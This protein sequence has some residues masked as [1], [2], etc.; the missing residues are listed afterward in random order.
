MPANLL[1]LLGRPASAEASLRA[2]AAVSAYF[3]PAT[4]CALF[5]RHRPEEAVL[6]GEEVLTTSRRA[7]LQEAE[8][9]RLAAL[10]QLFEAWRTTNPSARRLDSSGPVAGALAAHAAD[11]ALIVLAQAPE[12]RQIAEREAID[13]AIFE[14]R[15]PVLI[16][17]AGWRNDSLGRRVAIAWK[18][19]EPARR[20]V[21]A[22]RPILSQ[23][24]ALMALHVGG[25]EGGHEGDGDEAGL[26]AALEAV[27][28][29]IPTLERV[30]PAG[31]STGAALLKAAHVHGADLVVA[32]AY[33]HR[34]ITEIVFGGVTRELLHQSDLPVLMAH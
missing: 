9:Q 28:I 25:H 8:S 6:T 30:D 1:V 17:P 19:N 10:G 2:A 13:A 18:E 16:V 29:G 21:L 22:A 20:A 14:L 11:A 15:R 7:A 3:G 34:R 32:G 23:A 33:S 5:V 27:G 26:A 24:R 31:L 4:V 12:P